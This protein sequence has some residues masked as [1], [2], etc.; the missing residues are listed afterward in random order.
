MTGRSLAAALLAVALP[1]VAL[2]GAIPPPPAIVAMWEGHDAA[3]VRAT[4][5]RDAAAGEAPGATAS[6]RL[7]AG[8]SAWWLGVQDARAGRMDSALVQWRRAMRLRGDFDEGNALMEEL[9]RRGGEANLAEAE[10]LAALFAEQSRVGMPRRAPE[11]HARWA[12]ALQ[13]RGRTDRAIAL[14][15]EWCADVQP[16]PR[17]TRRLAEIQLAAGD[18]A[19]AWPWLAALSARTRGQHAATESLLVH[20]QRALGYSAE[21]RR[22]AVAA[23]RDPIEAGER[24]FAASLHARFET[25]RAADGFP[26]RVLFV[27]AAA[28]VPRRTPLLFVLSPA[29]TLP[30]A[31]SLAAAFAASGR[32]VVLLAPRGGFGS[33]AGEVTGPESWEGREAAWFA[34][35]ASDADR[36]MDVFTKR[37]EAPGGA[38]VVGASGDL[39]PVTLALIGRRRTVPA[40]LLAAPHLPLVEV[41]EFRARLRAARTRVF[42]QV[43][44]EEQGALET[45]DLLARDTAPGQVRVVDSGEPGR[46]VAAFHG[47]RTMARL[48]TWLDEKPSRR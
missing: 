38:W 48:L 2:A 17:W 36:V 47:D 37:G 11:A 18:T 41:A 21:G 14:V 12:W 31:D 10:S 8:E 16:R 24:A 19:A 9:W 4:L 1:S 20:A 27:P 44:P 46:G 5:L 34:A 28:G 6:R 3:G 42:V 13:R 26:V 29:D 45:A 7:E 15:R 32:P 33:V 35:V 43:A 25:L 23:V 40:L 30:A 39:V 22:I